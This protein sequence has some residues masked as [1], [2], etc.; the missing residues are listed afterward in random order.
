MHRTTLSLLLVAALAATTACS[1]SFPYGRSMNRHNFV[2]THHIP[3]RLELVDTVNGET[4]WSL[5]VPAGK[6]AVVEF[7]NPDTWNAS[8][9]GAMPANEVRWELMDPDAKFADL[10]R[11]K[12]LSGRPVLLKV[13]HRELSPEIDGTGVASSAGSSR[14][15]DTERSARTT[16]P[17]TSEPDQDTTSDQSGGNQ[18]DDS[19]DQGSEPEQTD[20]ADQPE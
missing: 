11:S 20:S 1:A 9:R 5:D 3:L 18:T 13:H 17:T 7:E 8:Q 10:D 16:R 19:A 14:S 15:A 12:E 6:Q 2:S 4:V